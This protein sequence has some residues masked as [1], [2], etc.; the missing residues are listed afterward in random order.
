MG[1][2][3]C[4]TSRR[5]R[6]QHGRPSAVAR[7][8][9]EGDESRCR[10]ADRTPVGD[11]QRPPSCCMVRANFPVEDRKSVVSGKSVSVRVDLGGSCIN[12]KKQEEKQQPGKKYRAEG[13]NIDV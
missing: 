6:T 11:E 9:R 1:E 3:A 7:P 12:K 5:D 8:C 13:Q 10:C 4:R 2:R